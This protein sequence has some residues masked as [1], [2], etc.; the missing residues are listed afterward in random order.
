MPPP[1]C[2]VPASWTT[3]TDG[4]RSWNFF[5]NALAS[6]MHIPDGFPS[7]KNKRL[8]SKCSIQSEN[9]R[10]GLVKWVYR[11]TVRSI[12]LS[13]SLATA[14]KKLAATPLTD[15]AMIATMRLIHIL[16]SESRQSTT[17]PRLVFILGY[18]RLR[19]CMRPNTT[20][21]CKKIV[22]MG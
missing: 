3:R 20:G 21:C 22:W 14:H 4:K 10:K 9:R 13:R 18:E 12:Y 11:E 6:C 7:S 2:F 19:Y 17:R 16:C 15:V 1:F 5:A 8:I